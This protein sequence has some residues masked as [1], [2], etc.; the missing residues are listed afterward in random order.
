MCAPHL[1]LNMNITLSVDEQVAIRA[2]ES[3]QKMGKS[4]NQA[5]RDY[6]E[7]LAGAA[8]RGQQWAQLEERCL[9]SGAKLQ[10]WHFDREEAN[11]R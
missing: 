3:A 8:Q 11:E 9:N 2:R 4:L 1:E 6:L 5:V 7:Q 10:G